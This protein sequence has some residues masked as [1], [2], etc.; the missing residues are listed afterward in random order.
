MI[1]VAADVFCHLSLDK[2]GKTRPPK[3]EKRKETASFLGS[4]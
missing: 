2:G 3:K 1:V 4:C